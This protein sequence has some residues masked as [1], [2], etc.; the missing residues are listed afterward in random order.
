MNIEKARELAAQCWVSP[1]TSAIEF[2]SLLAEE[3]AKCIINL[4]QSD[5]PEATEGLRW[6]EK[7]ARE[8]W[9][10]RLG[11]RHGNEAFHAPKYFWERLGAALAALGE[12]A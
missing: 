10:N 3:F 1:E 9:D 4:S 2:D 11:H 12:G 5:R 7:E 6:V 8:L